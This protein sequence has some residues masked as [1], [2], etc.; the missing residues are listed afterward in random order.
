MTEHQYE[1][2][3]S[4]VQQNRY[5]TMA[6][7]GMIVA[8]LGLKI[9]LVVMA[10][11]TRRL[12]E[13]STKAV[14]D[15][16]GLATGTLEVIKAHFVVQKEVTKKAEKAAVRMG[17]GVAQLTEVANEVK[18]VIQDNP[19]SGVGF[20]ADVTIQPRPADVPAPAPAPGNDEHGNGDSI[21]PAHK[22]H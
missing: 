7:C 8:W 18:K 6:A 5:W 11:D 4:E 12:A 22:N 20:A 19:L 9:V 14:L 1:L 3:M 17:E 13:V 10:R 21:F 2:L 16:I 15:M